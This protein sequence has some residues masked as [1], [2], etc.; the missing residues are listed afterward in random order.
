[1]V[2]MGLAFPFAPGWNSRMLPVLDGAVVGAGVGPAVGV[3]WGPEA[4][5]PECVP[6]DAMPRPVSTGRTGKVATY[7]V[8]APSSASP[9]GG[10]ARPVMVRMGRW[11]P[12]APALY[13][14]MVLPAL[15]ATYRVWA[16]SRA[17]ATGPCS[18]VLPV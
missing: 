12:L 3:G 11:S 4:K 2:R 9:F 10:L 13:S 14:V 18:P 17:T 8:P 1:M 5:L 7:R 6:T 16:R 15:L